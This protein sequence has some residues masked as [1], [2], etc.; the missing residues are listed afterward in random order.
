MINLKPI[1]IQKILKKIKNNHLLISYPIIKN[2]YYI[3]GESPKMLSLIN[4]EVGQ[5]DRKKRKREKRRRRRVSFHIGSV[6][7]KIIL[8]SEI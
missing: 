7:T 5:L 3:I 8:S 4:F 1:H 2:N 6:E